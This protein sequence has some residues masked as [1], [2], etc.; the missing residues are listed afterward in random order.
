MMVALLVEEI[1]GPYMP[2]C[3][4]DRPLCSNLPAAL[5]AFSAFGTPRDKFKPLLN[6][7]FKSNGTLPKDVEEE[8]LQ[9]QLPKM[10]QQDFAATAQWVLPI[11]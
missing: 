7:V 11:F 1:R 5:M 8:L 10:E 3:E 9:L 2:D 4:K 6:S